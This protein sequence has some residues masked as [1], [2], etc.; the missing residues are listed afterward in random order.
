MDQTAPPGF[1]FS[2]K[3]PQIITHDKWLRQEEGV[4]DDVWRFLNLMQPLA[5]KL[6]PI[7]I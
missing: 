7:L 3:L 2:A 4:E 6:G 1:I 5:E